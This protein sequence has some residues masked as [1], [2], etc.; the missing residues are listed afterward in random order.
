MLGSQEQ[1]ASFWWT[2]R[3]LMSTSSLRQQKHKV[4]S[5]L[6]ISPLKRALE[7]LRLQ[8]RL[9]QELPNSPQDSASQ[10]CACSASTGSAVLRLSAKE[11]NGGSWRVYLKPLGNWLKH[12][13]RLAKSK[14]V[15]DS[16]SSK[17]MIQRCG[18]EGKW[19]RKRNTLT[20]RP[21]GGAAQHILQ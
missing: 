7:C 11:S 13:S 21:G 8:G 5:E 17:Y 1:M 16:W 14:S 4:T 9:G 19:N 15:L 20:S 12:Y 18:F 10:N 3:E 6:P 2:S